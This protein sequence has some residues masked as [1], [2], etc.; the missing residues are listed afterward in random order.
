VFHFG[1]L[2]G[3]LIVPSFEC[4][5]ELCFLDC[6]LGKSIFLFF[7]HWRR[8][9]LD[10]T[11]SKPLKTYLIHDA[12]TL[13]QL[14]RIWE[15]YNLSASQ[16]AMIMNKLADLWPC[17]ALCER[18]GDLARSN[19]SSTTCTSPDLYQHVMALK[20]TIYGRDASCL[21]GCLASFFKLKFAMNGE[22]CLFIC[23]T[24]RIFLH[25]S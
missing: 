10:S 11:A 7:L 14:S 21:A 8:Y 19:W 20:L 9:G 4:S 16:A 25:F 15:L 2:F 3:A 5:G 18:A 6:F 13:S 12:A 17:L 22:D 24:V 1:V 23:L